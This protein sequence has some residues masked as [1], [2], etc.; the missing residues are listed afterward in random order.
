MAE[1]RAMDAR[2]SF[3]LPRWVRI[4]SAAVGL[5]VGLGA[6][7]TS[8][9]GVPAL[10][11]LLDP[12]HGL[13]AAAGAAELTASETLALDGL[14]EPVEVRYDD[15]GVPHIFARRTMDAVRAVGYVQAR[16]RL[17]QM[18]M[19]VRAA[20]GTLT[21]LVGARALPADRSARRRGLAAAAEARWAALPDTSEIRGLLTAY[22][23]GIN[24]WVASMPGSALPVEYRLLGARPRT[25]RPQDTFYMLSVMAQTL[26]YRDDELRR[27]AVEALIG[28]EATAALFPVD[29]PIQEPIIP[30][31]GRLTPRFLDLTFPA[32]VAPTPARVAAARRATATREWLGG[33]SLLS[34]EAVVGSNNWAVGPSRSADGR[35]LLAGDP[36]LQ[37]TLPSIWYE[38]HL[39][40]DSLDVYGVTLP[41]SPFP[42]IGFNRD[43][44]W[45][46]TN[47]GA[48][49][50]DFYRETVDD[51]V[52][53]TRYRVDGVDREVTSDVVAFLDRGGD[54]LAVDTLYRTHR[55][56]LL[57]SPMG[58]VSMRW[59][60]LEPS[61]E[62]AGVWGALRAT[63]TETW[64]EA[65]R[66][67][68]VPA[69]NFLV[70]D[71]SG[72]IAIR[73][74]GRFPIRPGDGRGDR[75]F[76]GS[77]S[78]SDWLADVPFERIPQVRDPAQGYLASANQQPLDPAT[79]PTYLGWDWPTP[80]RAMRINEILRADAAMTPEKMSAAHTDP[81]S[82]LTAAVLNQAR[83][84]VGARA[85]A[86]P[87][88][89]DAMRVLTEDWD[90][91]FSVESRG[92]VL[93]DA[94]LSAL[95]DLT[96]DEFLAPDD[97]SG[98]RVATPNS[99]MLVRLFGAPASP[100][101]DDRRTSDRVETRD[102]ILLA[103]LER[104]WLRT[105]AAYGD[106]PA[107]WR[108]GAVRQANIR[109]LLELPG[110]G[111]ESIPM[112]SGPGTLSPNDGRGVHGASWRF[113][114]SLGDTLR[115]WGT[116]PGGQSGNPFSSRYDDR[117]A[118]WRRGALAPLQTPRSPDALRAVRSTLT[119]RPGA[120]E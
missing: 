7:A 10:G 97:T 93:Y 30:V 38:L 37:L 76:D 23:E 21:E 55:G 8:I 79:D 52:A 16:D 114:V 120:A 48:D 99:M 31:P 6:G 22:S 62:F 13:I 14:T 85:D 56:P 29:A 104:A 96:W 17:F 1:R 111:R 61:N 86:P 94:L 108:W 90:G 74:V 9:G 45:T 33:P 4:G 25:F 3:R 80:W 78:A 68:R 113:V 109:H 100:W 72:Q 92:A 106:A 24:A 81:R 75:V 91:R 27:E 101:W 60:A 107:N 40:T 15:R 103:S 64:Y 65:M 42:S 50:V 117:L 47:T 54:T 63:S 98:R 41:L 119:L 83:A 77:R 95:T 116:Y 87:G 57:R 70:A 115:A 73:S 35:A 12:A 18:E 88:A 59:T 46:A 102:D 112:Q 69:Q 5:L 71:R 110:F 2:R 49:V 82:P 105:G 20:A 51:S 36:H 84:S 32:P 66:P 19:T 39:V 28:A 26:S 44:A 43:V 11:P 34:D 118:D 89:H 67:F 53:P 58:W